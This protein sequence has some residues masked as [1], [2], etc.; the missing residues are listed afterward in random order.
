MQKIVEDNQVLSRYVRFMGD[1]Y[2]KALEDEQQ[3]HDK[4]V[5]ISPTTRWMRS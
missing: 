1:Q 3:Q 4:Q 5:G 2:H